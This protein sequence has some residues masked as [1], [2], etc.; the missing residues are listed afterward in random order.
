MKLIAETEYE[1][2]LVYGLCS[3]LRDLKV[4]V[5]GFQHE[6][7]IATTF[8]SS[9]DL[10]MCIDPLINPSKFDKQAFLF[11]IEEDIRSAMIMAGAKVIEKKLLSIGIS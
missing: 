11:S 8:W 4:D 6:D 3:L 2:Q 7:A 5:D 9:E 1:N 10:I